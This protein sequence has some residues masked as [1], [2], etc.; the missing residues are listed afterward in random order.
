MG[1]FGNVNYFAEYLISPL[2]LSVGLFLSKE[3]LLNRFFLF[4]SVIIIG[5]TLLVTFTRG[6]YLAVGISIS[7]MLLLYHKSASSLSDKRYYKR[8]ILYGLLLVIIALSI[9]FIPHPLNQENTSLGRLRSRVT[10]EALTSGH[11]ALRR[12][13]TWQY[14]WMMI[15]DRFILGS[16]LG[17]FEYLSLKYQAD[18]FTLNGNRDVYPHGFAGEAHNEYLQTWSELG[19]IGFLLFLSIIVIF[20]RLLFWNLKEMTDSQR[21][22]IISLSGGV[23]A[24]LIDAIF[25]FP[26][27]LPASLSLFWIFFGLAIAQIITANQKKIE[28]IEEGKHKASKIASGEKVNQ[29]SRRIPF[30]KVLLS[31]FV[32]AI[33]VVLIVLLI[34][35]FMAHIY[36]YHGNKQL[37][38]GRKNAAIGY[39]EEALKWNPWQGQMYYFI[40]NILTDGHITQLALEYY[41][42]AEKFIDYHSL[43]QNIAENY[44]RQGKVNQAIPYLEKAIQYQS[45]KERMLQFQLRL[46]NIYLTQKDYQNAEKIFNSAIHNKPDSAELYYGLAQA[47]IGISNEVLAKE[48]LQK[49]INLAPA[50]KV[51]GYAGTLLKKFELQNTISGDTVE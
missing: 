21:A 8:I 10:P 12:M 42:K 7:V 5:T 24:V 32:A 29:N 16:G 20:Y 9:V 25:G 46:G 39:F 6:S 48:T 33:S 13:A 51:A 27:Q 44:L 23:T 47:Y 30:R 41:H 37:N 36:W 31:F 18:F 38:G 43:S 15:K 19:L 50:S 35:P 14:T 17:T 26:F 1:L 3:K 28:P 34:R 11:N 22:T 40:G 2:T 45:S 4:L 49:V